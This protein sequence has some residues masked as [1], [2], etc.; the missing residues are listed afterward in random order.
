MVLGDNLELYVTIIMMGYN[1]RPGYGAMPPVGTNSNL[2]SPE[3]T[4][5]INHEKTS[6]GNNAKKVTV[7][8]VDKIVSFLKIT[9]K[10]TGN[11]N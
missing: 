10:K 1:G 6:W 7:E 9:A 5:I 4:A 3:I 2:T 11:E 8:E